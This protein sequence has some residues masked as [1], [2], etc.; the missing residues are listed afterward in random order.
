[1][2]IKK[3]LIP[4]F[5]V[6]A[7]TALAF[8][9]CSNPTSGG[10]SGS[11][12]NTN[13][14]GE[15][16]IEDLSV[17]I[18][19]NRHYTFAEI[20]PIFTIP[21]KAEELTYTYDTKYL[22]IEN[23]IVTPIRRENSKVNVR[24]KSEHFNVVFAVEIEYICYTGPDAT[25]TDFY[26]TER[27]SGGILSSQEKCESLTADTTLFIGDSF[28]DDHYIGDYM[29]TYSADKK[30]MNAGISSTTSYH[31][32]VKYEEIIGDVAPK[33]IV[34]HI[35]TNNYYDAHD[36]V[37]F[38][39]ASLKRL[40]MY[41]HTSYPTSNIY[42]FNITQRSNT[43]YSEQV[44]ETNKD[45]AN[46]CA[47]YNWITCVDTCS[48]VTTGMLREDDGVHPKTESYKVFTDALVAAGCE[49]ESK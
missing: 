17:T 40:M 15:L 5:A 11:E 45:M 29:K 44:S 7:F 32:E 47:Q 30:V 4:A 39:E 12:N 10:N 18:D 21:E 3:R 24:A 35:G 33:N 42:W 1:M 41:L 23:N 37:N 31:W 43:A 48:K 22:K 46:W 19:Q 9:G 28:M 6:M 25:L 8:V 26:N 13:N 38:T 16:C 34:L 36:A 27:F 2:N 49:I 20:D 14:Y